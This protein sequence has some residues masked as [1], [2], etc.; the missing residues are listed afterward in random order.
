MRKPLL[1]LPGPMQVPDQIRAAGD[2]P[3]FSHRSGLMEELLSRLIPGCK[4]IFATKGDVL[5][6]AASGSGAMECA[7]CN[8]TSPREE[9]IVLLGGTFAG[10]WA[11]IGE[12]FNLT[13]RTVEVDWRR[14]ATLDDVKDAVDR[15]PKAEVLFH[16]WSESSTGVLNDMAEI[17]K[18]LRSQNKIYVA[19]AVSGLAVS[20]MAMDDWHIDTVVS[21]S[22]KG[23]MLPP[24]LG[25]VAVGP[26]AWDKS[27]RSKSP[28]FYWDWKKLKGPIPFT[29]ALSLLLQMDASLDYIQAQGLQRIFARRAQVADRIRDLVRRSGMEVYALNPGNG[30]TGVMAPPGF[31]IK[32]LMGRLEKDFGIQ[33]AGGLGKLK[34]TMFRIGHVGHVTDEELD[35]FIESFERCLR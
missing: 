32:A 14:G 26:R 29:P 33:I 19:D 2:R 9:V 21:G 20:P 7:V 4:A 11:Q 1:F 5:F 10:R 35:Y 24:G 30:I 22:Q 17:G 3:L 28:R 25:L 6:L 23:L 13:V 27:E 16:T 12:A 8:L 34:D 31:D 15:W 18:F